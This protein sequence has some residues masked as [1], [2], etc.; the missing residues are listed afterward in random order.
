MTTKN[1]QPGQ[2]AKE[3]TVQEPAK[4]PAAKEG[5]SNTKSGAKPAA[6]AKRQ[7]LKVSA[8]GETFRRA[9]LA[10]SRKERR[11]YVDELTDDQVDALKAEPRLIV[12]EG[13][14]EVEETAEAKE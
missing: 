10:F 12:V 14:E 9:G 3:T 8:R 5:A 1:T 2:G 11:L 13:E 6:K 7:V 4:D